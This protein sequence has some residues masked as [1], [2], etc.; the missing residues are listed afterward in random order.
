[1]G[2]KTGAAVY[3]MAP[4]PVYLDNEENEWMSSHMANEV[5]RHW[6]Q[7]IAE[8]TGVSPPIPVFTRFLEECNFT[9]KAPD[10]SNLCVRRD[11]CKLI[12]DNPW[13][14]KFEGLHPNEAGYSEMAQ[15][16]FRNITWHTPQ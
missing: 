1:M 3:I 7:Q 12:K 13:T 8:E 9:E 2:K 14:H 6:F 10:C 5:F 16:I 4:P 11:S 15:V